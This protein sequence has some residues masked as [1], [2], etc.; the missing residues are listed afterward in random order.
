MFRVKNTGEISQE[1]LPHIFDRFYRTDAARSRDSGGFGLGL[2][3]AHSI[4]RENRAK[5]TAGSRDGTTCFTVEFGAKKS[6]LLD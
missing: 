6:A 1:A 3:I 4:S 2:A 5:L